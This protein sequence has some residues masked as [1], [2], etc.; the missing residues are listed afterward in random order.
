MT[1]FLIVIAG[2]FCGALAA[3]GLISAVKFILL[4][5][6]YQRARAAML[7]DEQAARRLEASDERQTFLRLLQ[8]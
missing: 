2:S 1:I 4:R 8:A 5:R 7:A 6:A 3:I